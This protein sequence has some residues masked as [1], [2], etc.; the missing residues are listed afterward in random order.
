MIFG[1]SLGARAVN[2]AALNAF[3]HFKDSDLQFIWQTGKDFM[4]QSELPKNVKMFK[5]IDD[6]ALVYSAA[7]LVICR[8]GAS[9]LA[10]IAYLGKPSIFVPLPSASNDEQASNARVFAEK[11]AAT[12]SQ[13]IYDDEKLKIMSESSLSLAKKDAASDAADAILELIKK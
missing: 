6:M 9:S 4:L 10:E 11:G 7:D 13:L 12:I 1:G 3:E 8:S 5:F 2:Q